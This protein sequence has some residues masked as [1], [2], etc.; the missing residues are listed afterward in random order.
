MFIL[1]SGH[2]WPGYEKF[3]V[4]QLNKRDAEYL[5]TLE[6]NLNHPLVKEIHLLYT[7]D[8]PMNVSYRQ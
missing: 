1:F 5:A 2:I 6:S 7:D 3:T 4:E 8:E